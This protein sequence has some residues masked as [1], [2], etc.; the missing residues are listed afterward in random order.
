ML[1]TAAIPVRYKRWLEESSIPY[2]ATVPTG[3]MLLVPDW[4]SAIINREGMPNPFKR[5]AIKTLKCQSIHDIQSVLTLLY[6]DCT[7]EFM[8]QINEWSKIEK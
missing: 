2:A 1:K 5:R 7:D 3:V 8:E 4:V 6:L